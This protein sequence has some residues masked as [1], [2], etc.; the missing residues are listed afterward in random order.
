MESR[1]TDGDGKSSGDPRWRDGRA[2]Q[3]RRDRAVEAVP[4][5]SRDRHFATMDGGLPGVSTA[6][7]HYTNHKME[8]LDI[9]SIPEFIERIADTGAGMYAC[10]ASV[11]RFGLEK[12]DFVDQVQDI[13]IV[14]EFYMK[15]TG[16]QII[17]T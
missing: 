2:R 8:K 11:D 17:F 1:L 13:I 3:R 9:R 14:D 7:T 5:P 6:M 10:N 4:A 15:A 16:G 12:S